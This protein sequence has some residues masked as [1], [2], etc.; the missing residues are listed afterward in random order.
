MSDLLVFFY[1]L[2]LGGLSLHGLHT[3]SLI[4]H[5]LK[6]PTVAPPAPAS[7]AD[8]GLP[9]VTVQIPLFNEKTVAERAVRA[10]CSLDYPVERLEI[11]ILDDSTDETR[12]ISARSAALHRMQGLDVR[13]LHRDDRRDFKAGAL[14]EGLKSARGEF[15]A[16]FDADF[17][18]PSD[19]LLRVLPCFSDPNVGMTQVRW[20]HLNENASLLTRLQALFLDGHFVMES[21]TRDRAGLFLT[22]NGTAG[23]WRRKCIEDAGGWEG[24]T[25]TEDLDLSY[26]A[27]LLG[28]KFRFLKDFSAPAE[29][30]E[31]VEAFKAQQ[32]RWTQGQVETLRK[33]GGDFLHGN[34][35]LR[36]KIEAFF[37][38]TSHLVFPALVLLA[39][40]AY[41]ALSIRLEESW[42]RLMVID[43]P[44]YV[45]G[46]FSVNL[47]YVWGQLVLYPADPWRVFRIPGLVFL[48][49]GLAVSNM[50][51]VLEGY[52]PRNRRDFT[53]TP[54]RGDGDR[55]FYPTV[56]GK[57]VWIELMLAGYLLICVVAA[58]QQRHW[59]AL[60]F[61]LV[62]A[63]GFGGVSLMSLAERTVLQPAAAAGWQTDLR[64]RQ[65]PGV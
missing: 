49:T 30:P 45:L 59:E 46:V 53:R 12:D 54:K 61:L 42:W 6:N 57:S 33:L 56:R 24:D 31:S 25:L 38:L 62:F 9:V 35:P 5:R 16:V 19:F 2:L 10:A 13:V 65:N 3:L 26:R 18:P 48:G 52:F 41:P 29:L 15:V 55:G 39:L 63:L 1:F 14:A 4:F 58:V 7:P 17:I 27:Q 40:C 34:L 60:P 37:H 32:A 43:L 64:S 28:W 11:Q 23:V 44:L 8:S 21:E 50:L 36:V 47:F 51:A 22:F 20:G